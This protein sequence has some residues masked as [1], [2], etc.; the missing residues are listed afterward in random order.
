MPEWLI[1]IFVK[2]SV[3]ITEVLMKK[4]FVLLLWSTALQNMMLFTLHSLPMV[5][6]VIVAIP[7]LWLLM[8]L[9]TRAF[10]ILLSKQIII[11]NWSIFLRRGKHSAMS[12]IKIRKWKAS[13]VINSHVD[14]FTDLI[15][16]CL[17]SIHHGHPGLSVRLQCISIKLCLHYYIDWIM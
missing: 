1:V 6:D 3:D 16:Y 8:S 12:I 7:S 9:L 14:D 2:S 17:P 4:D 15:G 10:T 13:T 11:H 5:V